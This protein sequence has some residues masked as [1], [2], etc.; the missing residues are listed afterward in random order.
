MGPDPQKRTRETE[1]TVE[2]A[3]DTTHCLFFFCRMNIATISRMYPYITRYPRYT[4]GRQAGAHLYAESPAGSERFRLSAFRPLV[5]SFSRPLLHA[6]AG[7][8]PLLY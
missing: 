4:A 8:S 1:K 2:N 3:A 6:L 5:D 7:V